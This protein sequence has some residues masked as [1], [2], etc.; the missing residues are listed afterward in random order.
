MEKVVILTGGGGGAKLTYGL[1][2]ILPSESLTIIV[3]TGDDFE[4]LGLHISP[5][6]DKVMYTLAGASFPGQG[7][8]NESWNMM[9]AMSRYQGPRWYQLGDR[10]LA[11]QLLRSHWLREGYPLNWVTKELAR[12]LGVRHTILPMSEN[13]VCTM[14][15]TPREKMGLIQYF[16]Q[17]PLPEIKG[18]DFDGAEQAEPSR[19]VMNA[20]READVIIFGPSNPVITFGP[21]LAMPNLRRILVASRAPKVGVAGY[22]ETGADSVVAKIMKIAGVDAT[23]LGAVQYLR[24]TLT[25]FVLDHQQEALQDQLT[26]LGL[27]TLVTGITINTAGQQQRLAQEVLAFCGISV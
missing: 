22:G 27:Q 19:E 15:Q 11:I 7:L 3:N 8:K 24:E 5:D 25:H 2:Q 16:S 20:I 4:H 21:L 14:I 23:P 17:K 26:D 13:P 6:L 1:A 12:R 9:A 18:L 10:D